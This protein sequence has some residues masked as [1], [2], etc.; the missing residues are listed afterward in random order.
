ME[1]TGQDVLFKILKKLTL[2]L[3][4]LVVAA[5][6]WKGKDRPTQVLPYPYISNIN[7]LTP[8]NGHE[9]ADV[10]IV[11][12]TMGLALGPYQELLVARASEGLANPIKVVNWAWTNEGLHRTLIKLKSLKTLPKL[13]IYFGG[14]DELKETP[15]VPKAYKLILKNF[16]LYS[17]PKIATAL[18]LVPPLSRLIYQTHPMKEIA[19]FEA[20]E[21]ERDSEIFQKNMEIHFKLFELELEELVKYVRSK[22]STLVMMSAPINLEFP[23]HAVCNNAQTMDTVNF[24]EQKEAQIKQKR[25]KE[26][27]QDLKEVSTSLVGNA[28]AWYLFGIAAKN[29]GRR[30]EAIDALKR[31]QLFDCEPNASGPAFNGIMRKVASQTGTFLID[32]ELMMQ[33]QFMRNDLFLSERFVQNIYYQALVKDMAKIIRQVFDL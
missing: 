12:D 1:L 32:F 24:L 2:L 13:V 30:E 28:Q 14:S 8:P 5:V 10:L 18:T 20:A 9:S 33:S 22:G 27:Y 4:I 31:A 16:E 25:F 7:N 17:K 29:L 3:G 23:P 21:R 15:F 11:G 6:V 26:A 19:E